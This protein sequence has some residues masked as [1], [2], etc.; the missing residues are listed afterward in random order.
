MGLGWLRL[1]LSLLVIDAHYG[2]FRLLVQ[3]RLVNAFG[4]ERMAFVGEGEVAIAGFFVISGYVIAYVLA[5]KYDPA[6]WRGIGIFLLGRALRI[7]PLYLLVFAAFWAM[8]ALAGAAPQM[9]ATQLANNLLLV[10]LG[11]VALLGDHVTLGP[12]QLTGQLLIGPAWTLCFDL[13]FYVLAPFLL[14][15]KRTL[16]AV[17]GVGLVY[18]AAFAVTLDPRPPIWFAYLYTS[19]IAYLFAFACGALVFHHG[20]RIAPNRLLLGGLFGALFWLTYFPL[21]FTNAAVNQL[22]AILVLTGL[23]AALKD[24]GKG[25][26]WDRLFGDLTYSTYLLHLPLLLLLER[27][28]IAGAPWWGLILTYALAFALLYTFEYPLDRLRDGLQRRLSANAGRPVSALPLAS[29]AIVAML[30]AVAV[31]S[32]VRNALHGGESL[33]PAIA[34]CPA[35]WRCTPGRAALVIDVAGAGTAQLESPLATT[36]RVLVDVRTSG[37]AGAVFAGFEIGGGD[38][39]KAGIQ[40]TGAACALVVERAGR[41]EPVPAGWSGGCASPHRFVLDGSTGTI[42]LAVDS[43]WVFPTAQPATAA[44][45]VVRAEGG[46]DGSVALTGLFTTARRPRAPPP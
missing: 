11:A 15:W 4:V 22:L 13:L 23:V 20:D 7:Y 33:N 34:A 32:Y 43:L 10:P 3:P 1:L 27:F 19:P 35:A 38:G 40:R 24:F 39:L 21:G 8:L 12:M 28:Q 9:G 46:S 14:V 29:T 26:Q 17:W 41:R 5:R 25:R 42:V 6:S 36:Q 2:G 31:T 37:A 45:M 16:W 18:F 30:A 44:R